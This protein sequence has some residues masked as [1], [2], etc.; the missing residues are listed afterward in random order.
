M[1]S[2]GKEL[3]KIVCVCVCLII[4]NFLERRICEN[5]KKIYV[6]VKNK[7]RCG[8]ARIKIV[9]NIKI[10]FSKWLIDVP[11]RLVS[12]DNVFLFFPLFLPHVFS[13]MS[14]AVYV[15]VCARCKVSPI[16]VFFRYPP[17]PFSFFTIDVVPYKHIFLI[18]RHNG[19]QHQWPLDW[20][21]FLS[22]F[23]AFHIYSFFPHVSNLIRMVPAPYYFISP[24]LNFFRTLCAWDVVSHFAT[25]RTSSQQHI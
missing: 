3:Y 8:W 7:P 4:F 11:G 5:K 6:Y 21:I 14:Y 19:K 20:K 24:T 10:L 23:F 18:I 9:H 2:F 25:T 22:F 15:C 13:Y 12:P 1:K 16:C 17:I